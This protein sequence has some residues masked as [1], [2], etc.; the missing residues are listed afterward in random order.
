MPT[1]TC[2]GSTSWRLRLTSSCSR[3]EITRS[4][5]GLLNALPSWGAVA[6]GEIGPLSE[7]LE[8]TGNNPGLSANLTAWIADVKAEYENARR[9]S[10]ELLD[11]SRQL[12]EVC[13]AL[14]D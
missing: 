8:A 1:A 12:G 2:A 6:R 13:D 10:A 14:A 9:A 4:R 5:R 7:I 11:R 3:W